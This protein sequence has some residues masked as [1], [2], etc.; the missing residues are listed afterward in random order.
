MI[1]LTRLKRFTNFLLFTFT[2][3]RILL[4]AVVVLSIVPGTIYFNWP[5]WAKLDF[6]YA[7]VGLFYVA[8]ISQVDFFVD[9]ALTA[10][11]SMILGRK[12]SPTSYWTPEV[13]ALAKKM[14][15]LGKAKVHVTSNPWVK[16]PFTNA[17]TSTI[18]IPASWIKKYHKKE[19]L[20][21]VGHEFSHIITRRRFMIEMT[22]M[23]FVV[24]GFSFLLS[25][26][27]I[28]QIY[29]V[30]EFA[31][32]LLLVSYVSRRNESRADRISAK[33]TGPEGLISV[34][35]H[36]RAEHKRDDGS[37]THPSLSNRIKQLKP[38]LDD[39]RAERF[40]SVPPE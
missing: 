4:L 11:G 23:S 31:L 35:E 32:L 22:V 26:Y 37:L 16:G 1:M 19:I 12:Y 14:G 13:D 29:I 28:Y 39:E 15:V 30:A 17:A 20:A 33:A 2:A 6:A 25:L 27:T 10:I 8:F 24:I 38:M 34:F 9:A 3:T 21:I 36:L 18:N 40:T 5:G 7:Y